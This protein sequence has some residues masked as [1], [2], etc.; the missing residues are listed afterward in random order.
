[1]VNTKELML[2]S[3]AAQIAM[4][5][6]A[7]PGTETADDPFKTIADKRAK[8]ILKKHKREIDRLK[9]HAEDCLYNLNRDGYIYAIG[10]I[11]TIIRKPM[12]HEALGALYDTSV[13]RIIELA[14]Q[15][16]NGNIKEG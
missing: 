11:R 13:E 9:S 1:M 7:R 3:E 8:K 4:A 5:M 2:E 15:S 6:Q 16:I 10:K 14:K 12:S